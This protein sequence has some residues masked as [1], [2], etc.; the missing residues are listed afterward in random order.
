MPRIGRAGRAGL[1]S[2]YSLRLGGLKYAAK[3]STRRAEA[4]WGLMATRSEVHTAEPGTASCSQRPPS[5][6]LHC[7]DAV[8]RLL[9]MHAHSVLELC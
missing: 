3:C 7:S 9:P 5:K 2:A 6:Q 8:T 4:T 1:T